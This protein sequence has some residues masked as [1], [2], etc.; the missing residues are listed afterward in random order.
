MKFL[1][2]CPKYIEGLLLQELQSLGANDARETVGGVF[3][4]GDL[5]L[6][7][8]VCLWSRLANRVLLPL[9]Q[10][11]IETAE[12]LYRLASTIEWPDEFGVNSTFVVDFHGESYAIKNTQFGA[13]RIKDAI[14]DTFRHQL[15]E[16]PSVD[17]LY[18]DL[19]VYAY[20][21]HSELTIGLD[22]SG[23][24]LHERGYRKQA[25]DAPLKENV[26][27]A[28][29]MRAKWPQAVKEGKRLIDPFCGSGTILIEA[30]WMAADIAP[31]LLNSQ[32]GFLAWK[33]HDPVVW[34]AIWQEAKQRRQQGLAQTLPML[35]G[36]DL[37]PRVLGVAKEN[38]VLAGV[39]DLIQVTAKDV[40]Q[41]I[42]PTHKETAPGLIVTNPPYGH[43]LSDFTR[44]KD[45]HHAFGVRLKEHCVG[46]KLA[47]LT[48]EVELAQQLQIRAHK[49]HPIYNGALACQL[50]LF[51]IEQE[52]FRQERGE[53][54]EQDH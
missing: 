40:I 2:T 24:S 47:L 16:R 19:R 52:A 10:D 42:P 7:Y 46:W 23:R 45:L 51:D 53:R 13:Q 14:A 32:F 18:P 27:A 38:M 20:L 12:D 15:G 1:A 49:K 9:V 26:A 11:N 17:K 41:F 25:G 39:D 30:A 29:L 43:R 22:L 3:F 34:D 54:P 35:H 21:H 44:L 4:K 5:A 8:R 50:L 6:M 33:A 28:I 37:D 31:G 36:Y 48:A